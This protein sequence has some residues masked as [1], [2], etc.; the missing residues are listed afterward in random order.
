M[1]NRRTFLSTTVGTALGGLCL[2]SLGRASGKGLMKKIDKVGVQLYTVR[3]EMAK[4]FEGTLQQIAAIGYKEVEFAGY[5]N[6][7]PREVKAV[8]DRYGLASPAA[9][10]PV[11]SLREELEQTIEAAKVVGHRYLVCPFLAPNERKSLGDYKSL[12]ALL[13]RVG[14]SCRKAGLQL[15]YHNHDFEFAPLD[16]KLPFDL[17]L[18]ETDPKL[19]KLELDLYW[20][21]KAKQS[22]AAY[23]NKYPGRFELFHVKDMDNTPKGS[24]TEVG[25][26]VIDFKQIF[27]QSKKAGVKHYFVEQDETPSSPFESLKVSYAYL[28]RVEF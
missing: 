1:I 5:Y 2:T 7:S 25:R 12:T 27:A 9:H 16:G 11:K 20:I 19:V 10:I 22:P 21:T 17:L 18:A 23:F 14:E 8:L 3:R 6:R 24:F 4:D 13:N 15:A 26:G 28:S